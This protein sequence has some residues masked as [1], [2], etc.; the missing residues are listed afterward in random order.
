[1]K[2]IAI[3]FAVFVF[4]CATC[5]QSVGNT[6]VRIDPALQKLAKGNF[7]QALG[8]RTVANLNSEILKRYSGTR[9]DCGSSSRDS[10]V[11]SVQKESLLGL[12]EQF[13]YVYQFA[14]EGIPAAIY[15]CG[16]Y[17]ETGVYNTEKDLDEALLCYNE[18][19]KRGY[20]E[21]YEALARCYWDGVGVKKDIEKINYYLK[22]YEEAS[23]VMGGFEPKPF[24]NEEDEFEGGRLEDYSKDCDYADEAEKAGD[25]ARMEYYATRAAVRGDAGAQFNLGWWYEKG[26]KLQRD[27]VKALFW[28]EVAADGGD[29]S[30]CVQLGG[31]YYNGLGTKM[32]YAKAVYWYEKAAQLGNTDCLPLLEDIYRKGRPGVPRDVERADHWHKEYEEFNNVLDMMLKLGK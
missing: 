6:S 27:Y 15:I 28:Y 8:A 9:A 20:L 21:A 31:L 1:M 24:I 2:R 29:S 5:A 23:E 32:D 18:A 25:Y 14:Q 22:K 13:N 17:L 3:I 16:V 12:N 11:V 10:G 7:R 30:S 4:A 19:A 26:D